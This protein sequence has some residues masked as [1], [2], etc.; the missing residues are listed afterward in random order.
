MEKDG[1]DLALSVSR[2]KAIGRKHNER[3]ADDAAKR[4]ALEQERRIERV[5]E[6]AAKIAENDGRSTI[7]ERDVQT[8]YY[9]YGVIDDA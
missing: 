3:I 7:M 4:V 5:W 2:V 6:A 1:H 9:V 8:A